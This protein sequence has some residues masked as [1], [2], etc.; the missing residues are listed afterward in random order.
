MK[1]EKKDAVN[2]V[3][4][5]FDDTHDIY[6]EDTIEIDYGWI[7]HVNSKEYKRTGDIGDRFLG[8][9]PVIVEKHDRSIHILGTQFDRETTI[10]IYEVQRRKNLPRWIKAVIFEFYMIKIWYRRR[11]RD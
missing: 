3:L 10:K 2:I 8:I 11:R 5:R 6:D 4:N 1:V 7:F 9:G